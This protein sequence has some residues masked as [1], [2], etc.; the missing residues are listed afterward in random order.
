VDNL[1]IDRNTCHSRKRHPTRITLE[2]AFGTLLYEEL[3]HR[4]I[5]VYCLDPWL[6]HFTAKIE[7]ARNYL[8]RNPHHLNIPDSF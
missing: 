1:L 8:A 6:D 7:C 5:K 2:Q 4:A 3:L